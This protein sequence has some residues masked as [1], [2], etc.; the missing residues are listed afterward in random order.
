MGVTGSPE[1]IRNDNIKHSQA[2]QI[3]EYQKDGI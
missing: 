3:T 2:E 1:Y